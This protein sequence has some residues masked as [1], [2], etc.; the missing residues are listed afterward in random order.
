MKLIFSII[1]Y[2]TFFTLGYGQNDIKDIKVYNSL[3]SY[4]DGKW[5]EWKSSDNVFILN[6]KGSNDV[7]RCR[8]DDKITVLKKNPDIP[9]KNGINSDGYAYTLLTVYECI[10]SIKMELKFFDN[11]PNYGMELTYGAIYVRFKKI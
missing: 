5:S 3:S 9:V 8:L 11:N 10:P 6:Y 2:L 4:N 1:A 7:A